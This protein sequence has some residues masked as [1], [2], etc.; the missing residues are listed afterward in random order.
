MP[1]ET[2][3]DRV[4]SLTLSMKRGQELEVETPDGETLVFRCV[5]TRTGRVTLNIR[6]PLKFK[7]ERLVDAQ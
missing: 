7:I 3:R 5:E 6:A 2:D 4:G 1:Q